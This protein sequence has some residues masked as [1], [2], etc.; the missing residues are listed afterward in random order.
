MVNNKLIFIIKVILHL[1]LSCQALCTNFVKKQKK[2]TYK[3]IAKKKSLN[4]IF[5]YSLTYWLILRKWYVCISQYEWYHRFHLLW[6]ADGSDYCSGSSKTL[7]TNWKFHD[8]LYWRVTGQLTSSVSTVC[9]PSDKE[10]LWGTSL[11]RM[12]I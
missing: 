12:E 2:S 9:R 11:S 10:V 5:I 7:P 1:L 3:L 6:H 8:V 4:I